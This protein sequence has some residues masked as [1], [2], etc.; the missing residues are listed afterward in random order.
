LNE[1]VDVSFNRYQRRARH[2]DRRQQ[3]CIFLRADRTVPYGDIM[4]TMNQLRAAH[5]LKVALVG[6]EIRETK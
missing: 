5:Y 3:G 6:L 2:R 1:I 4:R